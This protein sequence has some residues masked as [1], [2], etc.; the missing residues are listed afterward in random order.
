MSQRLSR[1]VKVHL[2]KAK[3]AA[4]SAMDGYNRQ[5]AE[6]KTAQYIVTLSIA[7]TA[8]FHAIF[9]KRGINPWYRKDNG[10][11]YK[12]ID[13]EPKYWD[14]SECIRNYYGGNNP[15]EKANLEFI[16]KLRNRIEHRDLPELDYSLFGE[17]YASI[18][19]FNNLLIDEFGEEH[20]LE[21]SLAISI[22]YINTN[23]YTTAHTILHNESNR[24]IVNFIENF[25]G[26][27]LPEVLNSMKYSFSVFM[28]PK[29]VGRE[30][31]A[32]V[33]MRF[34][35]YDE[36]SP[37]ELKLLSE[38]NV[39]IRD[40]HISILNLGHHKPSEVVAMVNDR[41]PYCF[42]MHH[43]IKAWKFFKVRPKPEDPK[44][45]KTLSDFC[46]YD[47]AHCDYLYTDA[48]VEKL[49][50]ELLNDSRFIEIT[51]L[52]PTLS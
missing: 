4:I 39:L 17:C 49:A 18:L 23:D 22:Q 52:A 7:W 20:A 40:K 9:F 10:K 12:R 32:D 25:R 43:H 28:I 37:D 44:P 11:H 19:N 35:K 51:G 15:P 2:L 36:A 45:E 13:G 50:K 34:I 46:V 21:A 38:L 5:I 14:L 1:Q 27:L 8:L 33:A 41:I 42:K 24:S 26:N 48:W 31:A 47:T 6:F 30:K 3:S 29:V 16:I